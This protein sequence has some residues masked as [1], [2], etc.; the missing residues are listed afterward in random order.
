MT[1]ASRFD[2]VGGVPGATDVPG[3][4]HRAAQPVRHHAG[5]LALA[6]AWVLWCVSCTGAP[7]TW[8]GRTWQPSTGTGAFFGCES[9]VCVR[10]HRDW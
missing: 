5:G 1:L 8:P 3:L 10:S 4:A 7:A 6:C 2:R 9:K